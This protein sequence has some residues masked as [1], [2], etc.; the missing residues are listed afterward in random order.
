VDGD[1]LLHESP[2]G[3]SWVERGIALLAERDVGA[4]LPLSGPPHPRGVLR[5]RVAYQRDPR[6]FFRFRQ[7]TS[8]IFLVERARLAALHPLDPR[9]PLATP[10]GRRLTN[11][12]R[13]ARGASALPTWEKM[14][15]RAFAKAGLYRADLAEGAWHLHPHARGDEFVRLL[16]RIIED[17]EAGRF[18][19]A[20]AGRYNM[21]FEAWRARYA[22]TAAPTEEALAR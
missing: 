22:G 15:E 10:P 9:W 2:E 19:A 7:F 17:V 4:V 3:G 11:L 21:D 14:M 6:G 18:P 12:L 8:R 13:R 16:P 5:Q 20:Q 1:M